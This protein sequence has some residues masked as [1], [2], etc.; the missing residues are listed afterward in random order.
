MTEYNSH[1]ND[2]LHFAINNMLNKVHITS[3]DMNSQKVRGDNSF[4][5]GLDNVGSTGLIDFWYPL[6]FRKP[7]ATDLSTNL[8]N[9]NS[10]TSTPKYGR[11][12]TVFGIT[13]IAYSDK[14]TA[15]KGALYLAPCRF[16]HDSENLQTTGVVA[17]DILF[18]LDTNT[19]HVIESVLG[20]V[21][22][23]ADGSF[24]LTG[25]VNAS[26]LKLIPQSLLSISGPDT[27][28]GKEQTFIFYDPNSP[29]E[30]NPDYY[31][32][33]LS[34]LDQYRLRPL[35]PNRSNIRID[36]IFKTTLENMNE[37]WDFQLV[38]YPDDGTGN[39]DITKPIFDRQVI[40]DTSLPISEQA[41]IVDYIQG[42]I[43]LSV[44][45]VAGGMLNP[46]SVSGP[47]KLWAA[48]AV[49][50]NGIVN[51]VSKLQSLPQVTSGD[52]RTNVESYIKYDSDKQLW[53]IL[54]G[55]G[56]QSTVPSEKPKHG[57]GITEFSSDEAIPAFYFDEITES[58]K[59]VSHG[60]DT[61]DVGAVNLE[62]AVKDVNNGKIG[63]SFVDG[64][65]GLQY[66]KDE[67]RL[68]SNITRIT[69]SQKKGSVSNQQKNHNGIFSN[70]SNISTDGSAR[71]YS[72]I[73]IS[74][75]YNYTYTLSASNHVLDL[76]IGI[77]EDINLDLAGSYIPV[78]GVT[79]GYF[80][81]TIPHGFKPGD[82]VEFDSAIIGLMI[83][84][85]FSFYITNGSIISDT[86]FKLSDTYADAIAG[87]S[88]NFSNVVSSVNIFKAVKNSYAGKYVAVKGTSSSMF[89]KIISNTHNSLYTEDAWTNS[90]GN[91]TIGPGIANIYNWYYGVNREQLTLSQYIGTSTAPF[92][93]GFF[94]GDNIWLFPYIMNGVDNLTL[95]KINQISKKIDSFPLPVDIYTFSSCDTCVFDGLFIWIYSTPYYCYKFN[96]KTYEYTSYTT[97]Y[98]ST[99]FRSIF[100]GE[101]IWLDCGS[102]GIYIINILT[103]EYENISIVGGYNYIL[104]D[105]E[106]IWLI[107]Y[108]SDNFCKISKSTHSVEYI[109]NPISGSWL[110]SSAVFDGEHIWCIP[111]QSTYFL[112]ID[113]STNLMKEIPHIYT[114]TNFFRDSAFDGEHI[115]CIPHDTDTLVCIDISDEHFYDF[116]G[117]SGEQYKNILCVD[118]N[119]YVFPNGDGTNL[120]ILHPLNFPKN[121]I[122]SESITTKK[123][124][125]SGTH[126]IEELSTLSTISQK[127]CFHSFGDIGVTVSDGYFR[128]YD[129]KNP[130]SLTLLGS[131]NVGSYTYVDVYT[132]GKYAIVLKDDTIEL[133][134]MR[135]H[136]NIYNMSTYYITGGRGKLEIIDGVLFVSSTTGIVILS[137]ENT[138]WYVIN[139]II[140]SEVYDFKIKNDLLVASTW[141]SPRGIHIYNI[142]DVF[143]VYSIYTPSDI[144]L[145]CYGLDIVDN[146]VYLIISNSIRIYDITIL[147]SP[148]LLQTLSLSS[149][150]CNFGSSTKLFIEGDYLY[151]YNTHIY[152]FNIS[153]RAFP[154][155]ETFYDI[156][157]TFLYKNNQ[158]VYSISGDNIYTYKIDTMKLGNAHTSSLLSKNIYTSRLEVSTNLEA[159][160][161]NVSDGIVSNG[162][163]SAWGNIRS[164]DLI[165]DK[166]S[167]LSM[168]S[169]MN[170][171]SLSFTGFPTNLT[172]IAYADDTSTR[173]NGPICL[174]VGGA[175]I[176]E[177][178]D[179][180]YFSINI[181]K[182]LDDVTH[183]V[184][185]G[186]GKYVITAT[187]GGNDFPIS[188]TDDGVNFTD[189]SSIYNQQGLAH[190]GLSGVNS[191]WVLVCATGVFS[192]NVIYTS[193]DATS[194]TSRLTSASISFNSVAFGKNSSWQDLWVAVGYEEIWYSSDS[195]T[196]YAAS[197]VPS[198]Q[199]LSVVWSQGRWI[200]VC[201]NNTILTSPDGDIW[202]AIENV[203]PWANFDLGG[204]GDDLIDIKTDGNNTFVIVGNNGVI[205]ISIYQN[206]WKRADCVYPNISTV[207][208]IVALD[209]DPNRRT[210]IAVT[211]SGFLVKNL[212]S[213]I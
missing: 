207:P 175:D 83:N 77:D 18:I 9:F 134:N 195:I 17:G 160:S 20:S 174:V 12:G 26:I 2:L 115:W 173:E 185:Y 176:W 30:T 171:S 202:T 181:N 43:R 113:V 133:L 126:E 204:S 206:I 1:L 64:E 125:I 53:S 146:Y 132:N 94:D 141:T 152:I 161:I 189:S 120:T 150:G 143:N 73:I 119:L 75:E 68:S 61:V 155:L 144:G 177:S 76:T 71:K 128:V 208:N 44:P 210:F 183:K 97:P 140:G 55:K 56:Y 180:N 84:A 158:Y 96:T 32:S 178:F 102:D 33:N 82:M 86:Q 24:T 123:L 19:F 196:W 38:L 169:V 70:N 139:T 108:T 72:K 107:P 80:V 114:G 36:A 40:I 201:S 116:P 14:D 98:N 118:G 162:R 66:N 147:T 179:G 47:L 137:I 3:K 93:G 209:Y 172:S 101:N 52:G 5:T 21:L 57:F 37:D 23:F 145:Y 45:S 203:F 117:F 112:K 22:Q 27:E 149:L 197:S 148:V 85:F 163:I 79:L 6:G 156:S 16:I 187:D 48:F 51:S 99:A 184:V 205:G 199:I 136:T 54:S 200:A 103:N 190:N 194:W 91:G 39:P 213:Y 50:S 60:S 88:H 74:E 167:N 110:F 127:T 69:G 188:V 130:S 186:D 198:K 164:N 89:S 192:Q 121:I 124:Q 193:Q 4:V 35:F 42:E 15:N 59:V 11:I 142:S 122:N 111:D 131:Y 100:D 166:Y 212:C 151:L 211:D 109:P 129:I 159:K 29:V 157:S 8:F 191:I 182:T 105:G 165:S 31:R 49:I 95:L 41:L 63:F 87:T 25:D 78:T 154:V 153:N 7:S 170:W 34:E 28:L 104:F 10:N 62:S 67:L 106:S 90:E 46:N 65:S 58:W 92:N 138:G 135:V 13:E 168:L 81:S